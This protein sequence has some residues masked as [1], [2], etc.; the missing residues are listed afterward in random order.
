[1]ELLIYRL[2][3]LPLISVKYFHLIKDFLWDSVWFTKINQIYIYCIHLF[4]YSCLNRHLCDLPEGF[5]KKDL[6]GRRIA[7]FLAGVSRGMNVVSRNTYLEVCISRYASWSLYLNI[8]ILKLVSWDIYLKACILKVVSHDMYL[9]G[10]ILRYVFEGCISR[11]ISWSLHLEIHI[12]KDVSQDTYLKACTL[13]YISQSLYLKICISNI[14]C[15]N[16]CS[17]CNIS[18]TLIISIETCKEV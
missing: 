6:L 3:R 7:K 17:I 5:G 10:C 11:Y 1:M 4:I 16:I 8:C 14:V 9:K 2:I 12:S 15:G 13:R 18:L